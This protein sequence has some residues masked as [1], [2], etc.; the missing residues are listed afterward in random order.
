MR[1][2]LIF[3]GRSKRFWP[4]PDKSF[5]PVCG[6]TLLE[7]QVER[8]RQG[9]IKDILLVAGAHNRAAAEELFPELEVVTQK[10]LDLGMRGALLSSLPHC[11]DQPVLLVSANDLIDAAA[12]KDLLR[13]A[14]GMKKGGLIL[15]RKVTSYFPGGYLSVKGKRISGIVE[16]P[17]PGS[18]PSDLVNIVAHVHASASELLAVLK[19][20]KP[21]RDDGY[22]V[23][24]HEL[25]QTH[26]Y[27]AVPYAGL[28]QPVKYPWHLLALAEALLPSGGKPVIHKTA[29]IHRSAVVEGPVVIGPNVKVFA[30]ASVMGPCVIGEGTIIA[31]NALVRGSSI[32]RNC[33]IGYNTEVARSVLGDDVWTHSSYLGDS[34]LGSNISLGAGTTTGNL[35]LDEGDISSVVQGKT[36]GTGRTKL[37]A[38]IGSDCRTG[39]HTCFAPGVKVGGGSFV[40]SM[41]MVTKD[42]PDGSFVKMKGLGDMDI[43]PNA[44]AAADAS[45]RNAF[46]G[47]LK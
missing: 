13:R 8:L 9:G 37:G 1:A 47:K 39:I 21:T 15:A 12:Y 46:R 45:A 22:E 16:K 19:K 24:L 35:R 27:E 30:H 5:F 10:D 38:V 6:T 11:G 25:L 3:A 28:W 44:K 4:L 32:G 26:V 23:A 7:E 43:R 20:V 29:R 41:T 36:I 33:V 2:I 18:E 42:I 40:N 31:N 14:K 34:V 17:E